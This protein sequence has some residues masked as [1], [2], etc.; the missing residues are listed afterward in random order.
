MKYAFACLLFSSFL[1]TA[2]YAQST[3]T[4][5][6]LKKNVSDTILQPRT[7][8]LPEPFD[9]SKAL[10]KLFPGKHYK[11]PEKSY[12]RELINWECK[13]CPRVAYPDANEDAV[14]AFPYAEGV[15]T[16]LMNVMDFKDADS[17]PYKV[18]SFN[19]SAYDPDG[20]QVSR[21]TGG[22]LGLAKF[23]LTKDG[24]RL[25]MFQPAIA[26]Y[27][28][29]SQCPKTTPLLIGDGQ[30]AFMIKHMNGGAGG[31]FYG[32]YFMIAGTN[33][34][35]Q[36]VMAAYVIEKTAM[37][38]EE[39][40][41]YW[42]SEYSVPASDKKY[43]RDILIT[44]DGVCRATDLESLPD[45]VKTLMKGRKQAHFRMVQRYV[46]KGSKGYQQEGP[47]TATLTSPAKK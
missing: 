2:G 9:G 40:L 10:L 12:N 44:T 18:I 15:A 4:S 43:F 13:T 39:G 24:W 22:L 21:F 14:D 26:A 33:G 16:R 27:G 25:R 31:P 30:Y 38:E 36:Q 28:A 29:F 42:N 7:L 47:A 6:L 17:V 20:L 37:A 19:H 23:M 1:S 46:Y 35:Y 8:F 5:D 45:A 32:V 41:S 3:V 11:F 34:A